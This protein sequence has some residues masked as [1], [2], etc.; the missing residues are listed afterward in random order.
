MNAWERAF[1]VD[2]TQL[3]SVVHGRTQ[4]MFTATG[5]CAQEVHVNT[6]RVS[7]KGTVDVDVISATRQWTAAGRLVMRR[8]CGNG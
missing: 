5:G 1:A 6:R 2:I 8:L 3:C 7:G 4:I